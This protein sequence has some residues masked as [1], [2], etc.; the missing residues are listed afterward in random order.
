M[1]QTFNVGSRSIFVTAT[2]WV[3]MLLAV[4]ASVSALVQN[5]EVASVL[6]AW[7][8]GGDMLLPVT[9]LLL[10]YLPWVMGAGVV[11]SLALLACAI[12]LLLRLEWARRV[13]I[14]LLFVVIAA[15]LAGL[16]LQHEVL[17]A[18]VDSTLRRSPLPAQVADVFG[19]FATATQ[20][21]AVLVTL[22]ACATMVWVIRRLMSDAVRQEFA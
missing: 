7:Q 4:L 13:F 6:P 2:A 11:L 18:L 17:Q 19:G 14:G 15:N 22:F 9:R 5:A 20:T 3:S 12:G 16:W 10:V 8:A 1:T 21:M